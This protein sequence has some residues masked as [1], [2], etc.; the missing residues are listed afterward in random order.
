MCK[1]K[2]NFILRFIKYNTGK[3]MKKLEINKKDLKN[4]IEII[5]QMNQETEKDKL[6]SK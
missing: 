2:F 4:N 1:I 6:N 3:F 5:K